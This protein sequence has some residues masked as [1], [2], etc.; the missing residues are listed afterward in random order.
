M[1]RISYKLS[2]FKIFYAADEPNDTDR[3][4]SPSLIGVQPRIIVQHM[5]DNDNQPYNKMDFGSFVLISIVAL[6]ASL[7]S[8]PIVFLIIN[9][10]SGFDLFGTGLTPLLIVGLT[11]ALIFL[12]RENISVYNFSKNTG[13]V[14]III[15]DGRKLS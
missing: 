8:I 15:D 4:W 6:L 11:F 1:I 10:F 14:W 5:V 3:Q 13:D 12:W 9:Y 7:I 2:E